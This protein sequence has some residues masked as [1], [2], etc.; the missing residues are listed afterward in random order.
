LLLLPLL[1]LLRMGLN[2]MDGMLAREHG[3]ASRLGGIL[4]E[5]GDVVSDSA[6]YLPLA[7]APGM[8]A[9][10]IVGIVVLG[11]ISEMAGLLAVQVGAPR[12]YQGPMGKSDRA[13]WLGSLAFFLGLG[14]LPADWCDWTLGIML[15]LLAQTIFNRVRGALRDTHGA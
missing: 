6:L 11:I 12:Q 13:L 14:M 5:L 1:L 3:Q 2:A 9:P 15:F 4:N 10:F 7:L 8:Y